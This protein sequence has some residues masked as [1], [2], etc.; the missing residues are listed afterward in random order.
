MEAYTAGPGMGYAL[1]SKE[2]IS[3]WSVELALIESVRDSY[4]CKRHIRYQE[5]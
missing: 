4:L 3:R 1:V 5:L 2:K